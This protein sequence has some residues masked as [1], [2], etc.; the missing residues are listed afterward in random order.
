MRKMMKKTNS[1]F[2]HGR[3]S[4]ITIASAILMAVVLFI[5]GVAAPLVI[6]A[7]ATPVP[8][9]TPAP[10]PT[11][12]VFPSPSGLPGEDGD[13]VV[14][15]SYVDEQIFYLKEIDIKQIN[16]K[17]NQMQVKIDELTILTEELKKSLQTQL[18]YATFTVIEMKA[19]Q[20]LIAGASS[21]MILR[22]GKA[23]A[24]SGEFGGLSDV[25]AGT[26]KDIITSQAVPANHLIIFSRN[27][28]RGFKATA[29]KTFL[30]FK[31]TYEIK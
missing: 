7:T 19:G 8:S 13:P 23:V 4:K 25:T 11:L 22:A 2:L 26:G 3:E 9:P 6:A 31:G 14:T 17:M 24:I 5:A 16:D 20:K 30:L 21:E 10:S 18:T 15:K 28:G 29:D 12:P 27:D 1:M